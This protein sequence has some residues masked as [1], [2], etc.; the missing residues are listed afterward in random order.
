[1]ALNYKQKHKYC[2][3]IW[4][5]IIEISR[6]LAPGELFGKASQNEVK[7]FIY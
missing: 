2:Y 6:K 7:L 1:M 4:L 3:Y 5:K